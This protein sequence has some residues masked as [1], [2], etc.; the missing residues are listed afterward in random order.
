MIN[1]YSFFLSQIGPDLI[2]LMTDEELS[3]YIP[4]HGERLR[5]RKYLRDRVSS[6]NRG[7]RSSLLQVLREKIETREHREATDGESS[8]SKEKEMR[9]SNR[10]FGNKNAEKERRRIELG[11]IHKTSGKSIQIRSKKGGGTRK[12]TLNKEATKKDL[13]EIGKRL[14]FPNGES[15]KG[16]QSNFQFDVWDYQDRSM[17]E[18]STVGQMYK[19]TKMPILRFY[20]ASIEPEED[21]VSQLLGDDMD[22]D[23][24]PDLHSPSKQTASS[25]SPESNSSN[26]ILSEAIQIAGIENDQEN[27]FDDIPD[28]FEIQD[29]NSNHS[30]ASEDN[31]ANI[32]NNDTANFQTT[33]HLLK[34][35]RGQVMTEM[36]EAFETEEYT[37]N[38]IIKPQMIMPNGE[39]EVAED[40]GGVTRDVLAEFWSS[41][42]TECTLGNAKKKIHV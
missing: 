5:I 36:I 2:A 42:Y 24:L 33:E 4:L 41:F 25:K 8:Y 32:A 9:E 6:K 23:S 31:Y 16:N 19:D 22:T 21:I 37:M 20:L 10:R 13:L 39:M 11:W 14:F 29:E 7:K 1:L 27:G 40:A 38:S 18:S 30:Y 3:K 12:L 35:H 34:L 15:S 28:L 26:D 17:G